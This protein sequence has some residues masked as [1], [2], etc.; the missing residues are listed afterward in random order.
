MPTGHASNSSSSTSGRGSHLEN[1]KGGRGHGN[2][3]RVSR[4]R[5]C[6]S[7]GRGGSNQSKDDKYSGAKHLNQPKKSILLLH[8]NRQTG[9]LLLGRIEKL[10]KAMLREEGLGW[11][12]LAP[13]APHLFRDGDEDG[14]DCE[15]VDEIESRNNFNHN[16]SNNHNDPS[17]WQ[18]TWWHRKHNTYHG[19]EESIS[20]I[21]QIWND[22]NREFVAIMGFSQGSRLAHILAVI[23]VV[24]NGVAFPGLRYVVHASGYGDVPMPDNFLP[25]LE[26]QWGHQFDFG[27]A[28]SNDVKIQI[29][30]LHVMGERDLLIPLSSSKALMEL[31]QETAR[32]A[33]IHPGGHHVPVKANDIQHYVQFFKGQLKS[34]PADTSTASS[35]SE[36]DVNT[37]TNKE[38]HAAIDRTTI[39]EPPDEE[40]AQAQIDEVSALAQIFPGEFKLLS[41]SSPIDPDTF[42]PDDYSE[43]SRNYKHPIQYSII[44]QPQDDPVTQQQ[45]NLLWPPK[46]ISLR[47]QYTPNYPD[48][49]PNISLIHDMNYFEFSSNQSDALMNVLRKAMHNEDGMPCVMGLVYAARDFFEGGGL[50]ASTTTGPASAFETADD[51][52]DD[53]RS[54]DDLADDEKRNSR[55]TVVLRPCSRKRIEECNAQGLEIATAMLGRA[56]SDDVGEINGARDAGDVSG[57]GSGKGGSWKYTIGLV[58]K[59]SAGKSTFFNAATAFAR[60]RGES[61]RYT[62]NDEHGAGDM[63]IVTGG[64]AMA[65]HPFTTIDPN[66]GFCLVPAP[67][68]SCPEDDEGPLEDLMKRGLIL[69][70]THGRD[71]RQRRL[72]PVCLK[73]VAGLVP[74]AYQ[75]RGKGNKFLDDLTDADVLIH[76]VDASGSSD[77]E[78]NKVVNEEGSEESNHPIN[79]LAWVR[80]EL[81]EWVYFNLASRWDSI[82]RRGK[83]KLL[84]MF[85]GYKQSQSFVLDVFAAMEK[86][87][88]KTQ[89]RDRIFDN[90]DSWDEG[91]L[92]TLVSAFVGVRFPMAL[93]LNK[94]DLPSAASFIKDI[95]SQLPIHGAHVGVGLSAHEEMKSMRHNV[96][97]ALKS[98]EPSA[99]RPQDIVGEFPNGVWDTL[100]S[101][102]S[103]RVPVLVF[104]VNDMKS[105]EPLP[106]MT[107]FAT[108][109]SS[110]PNKGMIS[111]ITCSGGIAPFNWDAQNDIYIPMSN[112][113]HTKPALRDAL[114][115][116]PGSIV[117]DV[118]MGLK[119]AGAIEGEFVRA[120]GA[121]EISEKPKLL[122]KTDVVGRHNR[123]MRIMTTKRKEWQRK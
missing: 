62:H 91:D 97:L 94:C 65:P 88:L 117:E 122:S 20:R 26:E 100:Q 92:H 67:E 70:S 79:D 50:V 52:N 53:A 38:R 39:N 6:R 119:W 8:G 112:S 45:S 56:H 73:D 71:S 89:S 58:G 113:N 5:G 37:T 82:V 2:R 51:D 47:V 68:G 36:I 110:L 41:P 98:S 3:G 23:N 31:Y 15:E 48:V 61:I 7:R 93:A 121:S 76:V 109:D 46:N 101:A 105:Y 84:G 120:E 18:K 34:I 115:M 103:L 17:E 77:A 118:Y 104:P 13:D 54:H 32:H 1:Q 69:G 21:Q 116:K 75:G 106:G 9:Q 63:A 55:G 42:D 64:A 12:I 4:G 90:L 96:G 85:S 111:C 99:T 95:K 66:V 59:P 44:L 114:L 29:P 14:A 16:E 123:I 81:V 60:Q 83:K 86:F 19:L 40:H 108:R 102:M 74:G 78:G 25:Y 27:G 35:N 49:A 30:S 28:D 11:E 22:K 10:K 80:N 107:Q 24:T 57:F 33:H 87:M 72:I 43:E